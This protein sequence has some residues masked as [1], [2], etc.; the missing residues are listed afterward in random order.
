M[1]RPSVHCAKKPKLE[2]AIYTDP[3]ISTA[4]VEPYNAIL[5][6]YSTMEHSDCAFINRKAIRDV[7]RRNM[8]VEIPIYTNLNRLIAQAVSSLTAFLSFDGALDADLTEFQTNFV[9]F[10]RIHFPLP[11]YV[12]VVSAEKAYHEQ[13]AAAELTNACFDPRHV[14]L[15][16]VGEAMEKGEFSESS[17]DTAALEKDDDE[18]SVDAV[19]GEGEEY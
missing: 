14:L 8:D 4:V 13:L 10:P 18:V 5:C 1:E 9:S 15:W 16:Y 6:T 12:P 11:T 3:Q 17:E 2:F 7:C 19:E